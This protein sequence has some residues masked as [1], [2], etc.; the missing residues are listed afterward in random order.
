MNNKEVKVAFYP[1][2][3][4]FN[5]QGTVRI[6]GTTTDKKKICVYDNSLK[7]YFWVFNDN[8]EKAKK[9]I[10]NLKLEED[11]EILSTKIYD[12]NYLKRN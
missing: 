1:I 12:K 10:D 5:T 9:K 2:D 8:V 11:F 6:F 7:P 3:L 4:D